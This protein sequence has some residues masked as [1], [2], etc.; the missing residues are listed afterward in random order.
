MATPNASTLATTIHTI[1]TTLL[2]SSS[3]SGVVRTVGVDVSVV[4][5]FLISHV[6]PSYLLL[7]WHPRP[8]S[9]HT[10]LGLHLSQLNSQPPPA[11]G[12]SKSPHFAQT[13][14][15]VFVHPVS[16]ITHT[17]QFIQLPSCKYC[18]SPHDGATSGF[19][20][21]V[22]LVFEHCSSRAFGPH[23]VQ[24]IQVP[25]LKYCPSVHDAIASRQTANNNINREA[26]FSMRLNII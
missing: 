2:P 4:T 11:F 13:V 24:L 1:N 25:L 21:T 3:G 26:K 12:I 6:I 18:S 19:E 20:Q 15:L 9:V 10:P 8:S 22:S 17:V 5:G 14:S 16:T 23:T 7:H